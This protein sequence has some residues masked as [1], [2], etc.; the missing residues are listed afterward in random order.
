MFGFNAN[1]GDPNCVATSG[2]SIGT[3]AQIWAYN[4]STDAISVIPISQLTSST[5]YYA[6]STV[7]NPL[8]NKVS[9]TLVDG[10]GNKYWYSLGTNGIG[11]MIKFQSSFD[12]SN[13]FIS[14]TN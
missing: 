11:K 5:S 9:N 13:G 2:C 3:D 10:A 4:K 7:S 12:I 6:V 14:G 1:P 8:S